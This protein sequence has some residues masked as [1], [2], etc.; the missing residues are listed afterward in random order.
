[1]R[2]LLRGDTIGI[3]SPASAPSDGLYDDA[4]NFL[5][6][7]GFESKLFGVPA[8]SFGRM[9]ARDDVRAKAIH[10]AFLDP[11]VAAI[12]CSRGGYGSGRL[13]EALDYSLIA[14]HA[15]PF[16]GYSDITNLL[17]S[18][19]LRTGI[20]T[21]HGPMLGDLTTTTD[22]WSIERLFSMLSSEKLE[23]QISN[24]NYSVLSPG[25]GQGRLIGGNISILCSMAGYTQFAAND[26][27]V[28][29][30]EDVGEFLYCLDR[31]LVQLERGGLFSN[32]RAILIA[33][34]RLKD[35]GP[36]N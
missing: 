26:D 32:A 19:H 24:D 5:H 31:S 13:T 15:K 11:S 30:L 18:M 6:R 20:T 27:V 3:V 25:K 35:R 4:R 34:M 23:C 33:D 2:T 29:A 16:V 36:D 28:V 7:H 10:D 21:F 1:M 8:P 22:E 14:S 9:S 12:I 17:M